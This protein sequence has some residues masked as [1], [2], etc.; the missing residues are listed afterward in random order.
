MGRVEI[1]TGRERRRIWP[2]EEKL[3]ILEEAIIAPPFSSHGAGHPRYALSRWPALCRYLDDGSVEIDNSEPAN[4]TGPSEPANAE[5]AIRPV[6][7]GRKNWL[8]AGSDRGGDRAA[9]IQSLIESARMNGLDPEA[10]LREVLT[11]I[12]YYPI[13]RIADLLPWSI[14]P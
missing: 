5:R 14:A 11:R 3:R 9:S 1:I 7:L 8:F 10:Y 6:E 4:A 2:D 12:A 13:N